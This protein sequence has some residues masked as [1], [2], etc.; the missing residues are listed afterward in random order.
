[1]SPR[2]QNRVRFAPQKEK[3]RKNERN[4]Q[5]QQNFADSF[6]GNKERY[7]NSK[8]R[9]NNKDYSN[10]Y[11]DYSNEYSKHIEPKRELGNDQRKEERWMRNNKEKYE[12]ARMNIRQ[13]DRWTEE[14]EDRKTNE[15]KRKNKESIKKQ[16]WDKNN[17]KNRLEKEGFEKRTDGEELSDWMDE[18]NEERMKRW[19]KRNSLSVRKLTLKSLISK[20]AYSQ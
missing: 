13:L 17:I 19:M 2:S 12:L 20:T 16:E 11:D 5:R 8:N 18:K 9:K 6:E 4:E 3:R 15:K 10:N 7:S 14:N 1:M